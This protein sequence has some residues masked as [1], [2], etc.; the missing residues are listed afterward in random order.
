M[1]HIVIDLEKSKDAIAMSRENI[2][3]QKEL[4]DA[5]DWINLGAKMATIEN[6]F[7]AQNTITILGT[8]GSGKT[9]FIK[10]VLEL[11]SRNRDFTVLKLIDPTLIEEKGHIFLNVISAINELG[12]KKIDEIERNGADYFNIRDKWDEILN[13]LADGLPSVDGIGGGLAEADWQDPEYIMQKGLRS[14]TAARNLKKH[15]QA[16]VN[17]ALENIFRTKVILIAFDDIDIDFK[18]GWPLLEMIRKYFS[19]PQIITLLSGDLNL[20]S[21]AIRKQQWR[22]FGKPLLINEVELLKKKQYFNDRV[23]EIE[24]Q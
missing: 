7:E 23:T 21:L 14:V 9:T 13:L 18:K 19:F 10:S 12:L 2:I 22:N 3:H 5:E 16:Y 6:N 17:F 11:Y 8:R 1:T 15:F 24:G 4:N 20:F